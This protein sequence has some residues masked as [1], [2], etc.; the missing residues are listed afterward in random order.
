M[1]FGNKRVRNLAR[2][3]V[4]FTLIFASAIAPSA[5]VAAAHHPAQASGPSE[6]LFSGKLVKPVV[7]PGY[8]WTWAF[9][10][11]FNH[12]PLVNQTRGCLAIAQAGMPTVQYTVVT[13]PVEGSLGAPI[14]GGA[15]TFDGGGAIRCDFSL[16]D[17]ST[18]GMFK[19]QARATFTAG[20]MTHTLV[21]SD[22]FSFRVAS[23][24]ACSVL[25]L[26]SAYGTMAYQH[27]ASSMCGTPAAL[28]SQ[29]ERISTVPS[30][31]KGT[32]RINGAGLGNVNVSGIFGVARQVT[33]RMGAA[34]ESFTLDEQAVDPPGHCCSP[35]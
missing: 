17:V 18:P 29:I 33:L 24:P 5:R 31:F 8:A 19:M 25:T 21:S 16:I 20:G 7:P 35:N 22:A 34:G 27:A 13:C 3:V 30:V 2:P 9:V 26:N 1:S 28:G 12:A 6:C 32:H 15:A 4:L 14:G 23:D 11:N 10:A